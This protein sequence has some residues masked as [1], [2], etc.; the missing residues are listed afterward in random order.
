MNSLGPFRLLSALTALLFLLPQSAAYAAPTPTYTYEVVR[1]FPHDPTA[2]TEGLFYQDGDL[3]ESTGLE[4]QSSIRKE[5]LDTGQI[6]QRIAI[7]DKYFGEGVV[8][9]KGRLIELTWRSHIGF[10]YNLATLNKTGEFHYPGEGWA[11]TKDDHRLIMTDG[12]PDIRFLDPVTL[13]QIGTL[14]VTDQGRPV[15]NLNEVEW[16]KGQ[17][18][19][20]IWQTDTIARIDPGTGHVVGWIDLTGILPSADRV[21]GETDVLN[22]IAYDAKGDRLFVTGKNWPKLFQIKL[23]RK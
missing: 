8:A 16:V 10:I 14:H 4:G 17:I 7:P 12:T 1:T 6:L 2:F 22:G 18:Y 13:K 9:W 15:Q 11:L 5:K 23:V 3:Y 21:A 19:A 20:D